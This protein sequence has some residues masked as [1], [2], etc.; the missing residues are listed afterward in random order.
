MKTLIISCL[1]FSSFAYADSDL[2]EEIKT[3]IVGDSFQMGQ[4]FQFGEEHQNNNV[5]SKSNIDVSVDLS[6][7]DSKTISEVFAGLQK[8]HYPV[9]IKGK[10]I[11]IDWTNHYCSSYDQPNP[12]PLKDY[13]AK[14]A[15]ERIASNLY[16]N[17]QIMDDLSYGLQESIFGQELIR[18]DNRIV[19]Q[20]ELEAAKSF[21]EIESI[22]QHLND[23]AKKNCDYNFKSFWAKL[24]NNFIGFNEK[25][26]DKLYDNSK[27]KKDPEYSYQK[28]C[29]K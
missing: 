16:E 5:D 9:S 4:A 19:Y 18:R 25:T 14:K 29:K 11:K 10:T 27:T 6:A 15:M 7:Y 24:E 17:C 20:Q 26:L 21:K 3:R 28:F 22:H 2:A 8:E 23:I 1:F 13:I 12:S